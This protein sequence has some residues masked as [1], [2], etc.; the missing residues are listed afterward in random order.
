MHGYLIHR[1]QRLKHPVIKYIYGVVQRAQIEIG[2]LLSH[3]I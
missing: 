3:T 2:P 1:I